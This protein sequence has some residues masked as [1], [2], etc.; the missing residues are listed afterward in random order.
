[1]AIHKS[2]LFSLSS[3]ALANSKYKECILCTFE[4]EKSYLQRCD[5]FLEGALNAP[6]GSP[7]HWRGSRKKR[8]PH[9]PPACRIRSIF[10]SLLL[11]KYWW[12]TVLNI[13]VFPPLLV[14]ANEIIRSL[15]FL[16][17]LS[18]HFAYY[19]ECNKTRILYTLISPRSKAKYRERHTNGQ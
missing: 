14:S 7:K 12:F 17:R 9:G 11:C 8:F 15:L 18:F 5:F 1:M 10:P 2:R 4:I 13:R 3:R 16:K 6:R 19:M